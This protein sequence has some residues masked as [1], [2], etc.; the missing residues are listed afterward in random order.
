MA[1]LEDIRRVTRTSSEA[2]DDE[3]QMLIDAALADMRRVGINPTLLEEETLH[4][5]AKTAI[6]MYVKAN[7]G[8][9][10]D[11]AE[12]FADA[13]EATKRDL[14]NSYPKGSE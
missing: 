10:N 6:A 14:K 13:Y 9:D 5:L 1:L 12:R 2:F 8:Y 4:P 3:I 7:Y 11:E